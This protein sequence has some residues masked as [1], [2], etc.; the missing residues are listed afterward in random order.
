MRQSRKKMPK[1]TPS[2]VKIY[3]I[4]FVLTVWSIFKGWE[5]KKKE[6]VKVILLCALL[7]NAIA[8]STVT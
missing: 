5:K 2:F 6:Y 3:R 8:D 4:A 1:K 7:S